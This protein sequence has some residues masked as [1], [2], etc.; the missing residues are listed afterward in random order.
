MD[1][2]EAQGPVFARAKQVELLHETDGRNVFIKS[3]V[4]LH[5]T[6]TPLWQ[7]FVCR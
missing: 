6:K 2:K 3:N 5:L 4:V 1:Y 7:I